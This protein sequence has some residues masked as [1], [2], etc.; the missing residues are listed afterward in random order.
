MALLYNAMMEDEQIFKSIA[1]AVSKYDS[2]VKLMVL[3][4]A[5]NEYYEV[6]AEKYGIELLYELFADRAYRDDGF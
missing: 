1:K 5:K 3:S 4:S 6:L 2:S